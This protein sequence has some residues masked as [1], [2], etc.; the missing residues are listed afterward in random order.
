[1]TEETAHYLAERRPV[2]GHPPLVGL[3]DA[4]AAYGDRYT[5]ETSRHRK[6]LPP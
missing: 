1:M 2:M 5:K 6:P 3:D 4:E